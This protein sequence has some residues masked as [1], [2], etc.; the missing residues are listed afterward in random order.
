MLL[1]MPTSLLNLVKLN[2]RLLPDPNGSLACWFQKDFLRWMLSD[3]AS[4]FLMSDKPNETG[5]SL[6]L[7]WIEG[8]SYANE[9]DTCMYMGAEKMVDGWLKGFMEHTPEEIMNK[10]I[11][12]IKKD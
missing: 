5:L 12:S 7:D 1:N 8:A 9:M 2:W 3:G 10:S 4:A 6:R 11:F